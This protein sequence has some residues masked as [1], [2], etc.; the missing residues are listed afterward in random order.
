MTAR[1]P[2]IQS[3][4]LVPVVPFQVDHAAPCSPDGVHCLL[5]TYY[6]AFLVLDANFCIWFNKYDNCI[7]RPSATASA[8]VMSW[9][10]RPA[11]RSSHPQPSPGPIPDTC[12]HAPS[13]SG[14]M[15]ISISNKKQLCSR[16]RCSTRSSPP[17]MEYRFLCGLVLRP[18]VISTIALSRL[19]SFLSSFCQV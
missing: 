2:R 6:S 4:C 10:V 9:A 15:K 17:P 5:R 11:M 12:S 13:E 16:G 19:L 7:K 1:C 8:L 3:L 18:P 14:K